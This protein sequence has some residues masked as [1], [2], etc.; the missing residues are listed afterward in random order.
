MNK[1]FKIAGSII[2]DATTAVIWD[3]LTNPKKIAI[4]L[5]VEETLTDWKP[6]ST[7][8]WQGEHGGHKF[9]DKGKV[10]ENQFGKLLRFEYWSG[11]FGAEDNPENY[12]V[13]TYLLEKVSDTQIKLTYTREKIPT[14]SEH[15]IFE[16]HLP[17][18][19]QAIKDVAE[20]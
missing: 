12:S 16:Q 2:I 4:Y 3:V 9:R 15:L 1:N 13:V 20:Q 11:S 10:L 18:M 14:E 17:S 6:G 7:I 19:L 8:V 5:G